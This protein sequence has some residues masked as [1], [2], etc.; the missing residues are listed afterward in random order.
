[1]GL[2][3]LR[4][5][6]LG[7]VQFNLFL[8]VPVVA[9]LLPL[10]VASARPTGSGR[11]WG[12]LLVLALLESLRIVVL[13]TGFREDYYATYALYNTTPL[14]VLLMAPGLLG[15]PVSL[16]TLAGAV[17][18]VAGGF[19]FF[20][21]G[22]LRVAGALSALIQALLTVLSK[23]ALGLSAPVQFMFL[24]Y[25]LSTVQLLGIELGRG[26][27]ASTWAAWRQSW[28]AILPLSVL[29][30]VAIMAYVQ[31]LAMAPATHVA[32][33][34][35]SSLVF[36]FALSVGWL[37]ERE[38]WGGKLGGTVLIAAGAVVIALA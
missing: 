11:L 28:R 17:F 6:T 38:Q 18:V 34:G 3:K 36:G 5:Q 25:G 24:L 7:R 4:L 33:L 37:G 15:E 2:S 32:V 1:M 19:V 35:R 12:L 16:S 29:N 8:R 22:R 30:V 13:S 26:A 23:Q 31:A 9:M 10:F 27:P 14:F 20:R 21:A